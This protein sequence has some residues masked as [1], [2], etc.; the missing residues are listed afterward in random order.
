MNVNEKK[1]DAVKN[2]KLKKKQL[3]ICSLGTLP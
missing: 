1:G 3:V 2:N